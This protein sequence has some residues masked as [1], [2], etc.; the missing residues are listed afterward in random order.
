MTDRLFTSIRE[1]F[2]AVIFDLD[3][4]L[5]DT[6]PDI[7]AY[8]NEMLFELGRPGLDLGEV[9]PMIGDGVRSLMI[10]AFEASG[11]IPESLDIDDL[12]R[13]Y[14]E[15]YSAEP[16]RVSQPYPAMVET[17]EALAGA[18]LS[19]GICTNKPQLP[20]GRLLARFDLDRF[21]AAAIGGDALPIKKPDP[22]HLLAVLE[23]LDV[24]PAR[25]VLIGDSATDLKTARAADVPCILVSFGYTAVP[26]SALGADRVIDHAGELIPTLTNLS[27]RL[28][29][30][31]PAPYSLGNTGD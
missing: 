8:L 23:R 7:L 16:A 15:R 18:G 29:S 5:V 30:P 4:T 10:R 26:A 21:F 27:P 19:L 24:D 25:A 22:A 12:F 20:T 2:D 17:L 3:G 28:T 11:G 6:A 31:N 9:R 13:R 1:R 14:L